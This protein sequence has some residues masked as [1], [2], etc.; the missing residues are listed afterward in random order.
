MW[1]RVGLSRPAGARDGRYGRALLDCEKEKLSRELWV[2][3][4]ECEL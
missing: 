2:L 4:V 1:L 3:Q